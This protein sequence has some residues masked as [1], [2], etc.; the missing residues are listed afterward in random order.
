MG[1]LTEGVKEGDLTGGCQADASGSTTERDGLPA[2]VDSPH[3]VYPFPWEVPLDNVYLDGHKVPRSRMRGTT[4]TARES[5]N[6][7]IFT[8]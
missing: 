4:N 3:E 5:G 7:G 1:D 8:G 6:D 2:P